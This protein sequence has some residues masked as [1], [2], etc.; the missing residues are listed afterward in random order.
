MSNLQK[1]LMNVGYRPSQKNTSKQFREQRL[2]KRL[3]AL[4]FSPSRNLAK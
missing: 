2:L 1:A 3:D 4:Q